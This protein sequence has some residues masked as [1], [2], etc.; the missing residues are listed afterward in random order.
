MKE[1][2]SLPLEDY[3]WRRKLALVVLSWY[4]GRWKVRCELASMERDTAEYD[5]E[6]KLCSRL[7]DSRETLRLLLNDRHLMD[8]RYA[9]H[10]G[11]SQEYLEAWW[12][13]R[14]LAVE[15]FEQSPGD[16]AQRRITYWFK[17]RRKKGRKPRQ[18]EE[19]GRT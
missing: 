1:G 2:D 6:F 19:V 16:G 10:R 4:H 15:A 18:R 12:K 3:M 14:E 9:P 8:E 17:A 7:W 11:H 5:R 13:T